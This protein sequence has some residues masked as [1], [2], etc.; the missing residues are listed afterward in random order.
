MFRLFLAIIKAKLGMAPDAILAKKNEYDRIIN[1]G[2][3]MKLGG[4]NNIVI[5]PPGD[6]TL[7]ISLRKD[8]SDLLVFDSVWI[9]G[10]YRK[11]LEL[12]LDKAPADNELVIVDAGAN[13]GL[14]SL[15]F[16]HNLPN[17]KIYALEPDPDNF[18]V[19]T[20]NIEANHLSNIHALNVALWYKDGSLHLN[21]DFRDG[22]AWSISV[23][24]QGQGMDC[25][26]V[27]ID[28][29]IDQ[30]QLEKIDLLKIDIEGSEKYLFDDESLLGWLAKVKLMVI[31]IH[32]E[33]ADRLK[34]EERLKSHGLQIMQDGYNTICYRDE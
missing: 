26:G 16:Q 7:K 33:V 2:Y 8:Q 13:I 17:A 18:K 15:Y 14:T 23:S 10:D 32:D 25:Q 20:R 30:Y 19:M 4:Q 31:E 11:P 12:I 5:L 1:S 9:R 6:K 22:E 28:H 21:S 34:I 29:L 24:D 3:H 27:T